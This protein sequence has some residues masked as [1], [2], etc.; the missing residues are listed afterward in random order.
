MLSVFFSDHFDEFQNSKI[1]MSFVV[2]PIVIKFGAAMP[3]IVILSS[4][5]LNSVF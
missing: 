5:I 3:S 4:S 2:M 1:A